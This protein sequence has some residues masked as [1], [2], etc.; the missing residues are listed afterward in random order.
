MISSI[1]ARIFTFLE[2]SKWKYTYSNY[3]KKYNL[4]SS[5]LFG[6]HGTLIYGEGTFLAGECS[7]VN[8]AWIQLAKDA[9]VRVGRNCRIAHN[10][11]IYTESMD[12]DSDL[13]VDPWGDSEKKK[14]FG[15]VVI[16]D[17]VWIGANVFINPGITIGSNSVIGA[18]S[19]VT[20][21]IAPNS[22]MGGVPAKLIRVKHIEG[23]R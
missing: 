12:P 5:F 10:V 11:R 6:A 19:V 13:D 7:Y 2:H 16:E 23:I 3:R 17:G 14:K 21:D 9:C 1:A 8:Q 15:D 4:P 18:N 22:I 20:K